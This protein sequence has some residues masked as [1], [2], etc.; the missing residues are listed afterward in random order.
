LTLLFIQ[1][2]MTSSRLPGKVLKKLY[3]KAI[4]E[5]ITDNIIE[6]FGLEKV[7][8]LTSKEQT[9]LPI[10]SFAN[11]RNIQVIQGSLKNVYDRFRH[12]IEQFGAKS[13]VRICGDSP[14]IDM[15]L[16]KKG[17]RLYND[18]QADIITNVFPRTF[19][20][21]QSVEVVNSTTF[22]DPSFVNLPNFSEEHITSAFYK[23]T[24]DF[25]IINF[26]NKDS[27]SKDNFVV[28]TADDFKR[29]EK[30]LIDHN[31]QYPSFRVDLTT[32]SKTLGLLNA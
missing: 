6:N 24:K 5:H 13:F 3:N 12:A 1:A 32:A 16:I 18:N 15:G 22:L 23:D 9:D 14:L 7:V 31:G 2:R 29:I 21:G 28:D 4:L 11:E 17:I 30:F 10:V 8:V 27:L 26:Y 19:P 25:N 20:K